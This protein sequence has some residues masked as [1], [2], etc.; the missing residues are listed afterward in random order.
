MFSCENFGEAA[1]T[2]A[3]TSNDGSPDTI[4][5]ATFSEHLRS[6][7]DSRP[8]LTVA[9]LD[10]LINP[11]DSFYLHETS[12][13]LRAALP[14]Y[15]WRTISLSAAEATQD[16]ISARPDF[17][18]APS[19]FAASALLTQNPTVFRIAT[20]KTPNA[21]K[22]EASTGCTFVVRRTAGI[23]TLKDMRG[24]TAGA[25]LPTAVDGWLAAAG[26]IMAAGYDPEH[27]FSHIDFRNNAYPDVI[28]SLL[29]GRIDVA[30]LPS[31]LFETLEIQGLIDAFVL[32]VAAPKN[33]GLSCLHSTA[34][35]PDV[36]LLALETAPERAVRDVTI[37]ILSLRSTEEGEWLTNV[38]LTSVQNLMRS[39]KTGPFSYLRDMSVAGIFSRWRH[40]ILICI[41][42][43]V[44][45]CANEL[46]LHVLVRKRT[47]E[48]SRAI[49]EQKRSALEAGRTRTI[50]S[51]FERR[52]VVQQMSGMIA[53]EIN[54]PIGAIRTYAVILKVARK[55][56]NLDTASPEDPHR[57]A[58][59]Q[60]VDGIEC[61]AMRIANI[62]ARVRAYAKR[63]C[64]RHFPCS[65]A[66]ILDKSVR[67]IQGELPNDAG[68]YFR[69]HFICDRTRLC[70]LGDPLELEILFLNLLRNATE[71]QR[72][73]AL[74]VHRNVISIFI[75]IIGRR[76][77]VSIEN[78]TLPINLERIAALNDCSIGLAADIL[79]PNMTSVRE[80]VNAN[81]CN[82]HGLGLGLSICRGIADSHCA[83]LHFEA[84]DHGV[85]DKTNGLLHSRLRVVVEMEWQGDC[86]LQINDVENSK[87]V[88]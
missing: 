81:D 8:L 14:Q 65:L 32:D 31:C 19:G 13:K 52:S 83:S 4:S 35:Y 57:M 17:L 41:L 51:R 26:E 49:S 7:G 59:H 73:A 75:E 58:L 39:L 66:Q 82:E 47:K 56:F 10:T 70:V 43:L 68:I 85:F 71:A 76:I 46:R 55:R 54:G 25:S 38:P 60:A 62:V 53:H 88:H 9:I 48:L 78:A 67:A 2:D 22:A 34:L 86:K 16:I 36:S 30:I 77:R 45:L 1:I 37:A 6:Q 87:G 28:S 44:L 33:E 69:L 84:A 5:A 20:R 15:R 12:E 27:F 72:S 74:P 11:Y 80:I 29:A 61:E 40:E 23:H 18:F 21:E 3:T 64:A 50:L 63:T 42:L 79:Q 24:H